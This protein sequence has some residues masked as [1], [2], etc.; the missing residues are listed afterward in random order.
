MP[1]ISLVVCVYRQHDLLE[2]L[3]R[4]SRN[5]YDDLVVVHDGPDM[6]GVKAVGEAVGGRFF[7]HPRIGSL[8]GQSPFAW[9]KARHD[10][11]LRLDADEIP[12]VEMKAWL[13]EFREA[14]EPPAYISGYTCLWP[15]WNGKRAV[16][17]NWPDGRIFLFHKQRVR[18][19]GMVEVTPIPDQR[20]EPLKLVL[21]HEPLRKSYGVRNIFIRRQAYHW[22][23]VISQS[24]MGPPTALPCWR[25]TSEAWPAEWEYVRRHPVRHSL[26]CLF[27]YPLCQVKDML[28]AGEM[29]R[30]SAC[31]NPGLHHFMLG[32]RVRSEIRRRRKQ[33]T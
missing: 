21:R 29:P 1:A 2:R 23:E 6:D 19:I 5:C 24:L 18:F 32:L 20:F 15:L 31:L 9:E 7:E 4:E 27:W 8:E 17:R 16:T 12:S 30:L 26:R 28:R 13:Q 33:R 10:W 11:I 3:L 22:R 25:W 14:P